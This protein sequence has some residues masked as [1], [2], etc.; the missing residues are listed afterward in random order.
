[1]ITPAGN[2]CKYFYGDYYRGRS[3]EECRLL[4]DSGDRQGW[5]PTLCS[6]CPVPGIL[7]ANACNQMRLRGKIHRPFPYIQKHVM[8]TAYCTRSESIV[9]EPK[10]GCGQ[11]HPL[12]PIFTGDFDGSDTSN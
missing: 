11:C 2:E 3:R 1:M 9:S 6:S 10:I 7:R 8:V 4:I 5:K 12:P